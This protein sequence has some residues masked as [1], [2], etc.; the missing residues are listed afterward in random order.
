MGPCS[1]RCP[2]KESRLYRLPD[3][4]FPTQSAKQRAQYSK[5]MTEQVLDLVLFCN[6]PFDVAASQRPS[7][8][9]AMFKSKSFEAW[10]KAREGRIKLAVEGVSRIDKAASAI[11]RALVR[12]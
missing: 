7:D 6:Q 12:R 11:I 10:K 9:E 1:C 8:I 3:F 5:A 2:K 4:L